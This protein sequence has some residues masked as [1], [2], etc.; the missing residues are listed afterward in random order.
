MHPLKE[1]LGNNQMAAEAE[2]GRGAEMFG[3]CEG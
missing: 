2:Q 3:V 1:H